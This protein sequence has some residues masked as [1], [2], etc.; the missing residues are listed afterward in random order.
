MPSTRCGID[1]IGVRGGSLVLLVVLVQ[2]V[3]MFQVHYVAEMCAYV[4]CTQH[5]D[6]AVLEYASK[7]V[8]NVRQRHVL[9]YCRMH[10]ET[11]DRKYIRMHAFFNYFE[12]PE[13]FGRISSVMSRNPLRMTCK[14]CNRQRDKRRPLENIVR[15]L[16]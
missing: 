1:I 12:C 9:R 13:P 16:L 2:Y 7:H 5:K 8:R 6:V 10:A 11:T 15:E 14:T 3:C 4:R